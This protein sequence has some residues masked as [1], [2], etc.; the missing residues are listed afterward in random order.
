M[1][2]WEFFGLVESNFFDLLLVLIGLF[3]FQNHFK[4]KLNFSY[5]DPVGYQYFLSVFA[6][7]VVIFLYVIEIISIRILISIILIGLSFYLGLGKFPKHKNH[8]QFKGLMNN[9][10]P[11]FICYIFFLGLTI[12]F[13]GLPIFL[14][15]RVELSSIES[16]KLRYISKFLNYFRPIILFLSFII[17]N[18]PLKSARRYAWLAIVICSLEALTSGSK[19]GL[20]LLILYP[21]L[22]LRIFSTSLIPLLKKN[23]KKMIIVGLVTI[24]IITIFL[25]QNPAII[26]YRAIMTGDI[27]YHV[28]PNLEFWRENY[29]IGSSAIFPSIAKLL[30]TVSISTPGFNLGNDIFSFYYNIKNMGPTR[31]LPLFLFLNLGL[32]S[33]IIFSFIAGRLL[34]YIIIKLITRRINSFYLFIWVP[35]FFSIYDIQSDYGVS[36]SKSLEVIIIGLPLLLTLKILRWHR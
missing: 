27:Y 3:T 15:S 23:Y 18:H 33:S 35:L 34:R 30:G 16:G 25:Y 11:A 21:T 1:K 5:F 22:I 7:S 12:L 20:I 24:P 6:I 28:L 2:T 13:F 31:R 32:F 8:F 36:L 10:Y 26:L 19:S 17:I 4:R 14:E 9:F 29:T